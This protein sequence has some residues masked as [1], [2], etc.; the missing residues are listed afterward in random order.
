[1]QTKTGTRFIRLS[2]AR[3]RGIPQAFQVSARVVGTIKKTAAAVLTII[4]LPMA[5]SAADDGSAPVRVINAQERQRMADY[6]TNYIDARAIVTSFTTVIGDDVD[7]ADMYAQPALRQP[8]MEGH[9]IELAPR[10]FPNSA[11]LVSPQ[12]RAVMPPQTI[13]TS[14][15]QCPEGS[16]PIR[17]LTMETL[18]RFKTLADFRKKVPSHLGQVGEFQLDRTDDEE[19]PADNVTPPRTGAT[20][21][22][23]YA[24]AY[25]SVANG[26][27]GDRVEPLE[28]VYRALGRV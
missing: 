17:R 2:D 25:Q 27:G 23:Q 20:S 26:G 28:P 11:G 16:V 1:M 22:H 8:G 10:T 4:L 5:V 13:E 3:I 6:L 24:H 9:A 14:D 19:F 15:A 21:L 7:C 18:K 12:S